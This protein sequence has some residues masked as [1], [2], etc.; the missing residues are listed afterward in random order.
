M[1]HGWSQ[2][3]IH[4]L[5]SLDYSYVFWIF[6]H[7]VQIYRTFYDELQYP[8]NSWMSLCQKMMEN[9]V[10]Q[11]QI[12]C[13]SILDHHILVFDRLVQLYSLLILFRPR[14]IKKWFKSLY[15]HLEFF[16]LKL[17]QNNKSYNFI[18]S[19]TDI[20]NKMNNNDVLGFLG[21]YL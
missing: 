21:V 12:L 9:L 2:I 6:W 8:W 19:P 11:Q 1:L 17:L 16:V 20:M 18:C 15:V 13:C 10:F 7:W 4:A 3:T 14:K 5:F